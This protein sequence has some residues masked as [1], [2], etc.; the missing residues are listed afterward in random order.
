MSNR[1]GRERKRDCDHRHEVL[2]VGEY[3][4]L[5]DTM[6]GDIR[7]NL[8]PVMI[9]RGARDRLTCAVLVVLAKWGWQPADPLEVRDILFED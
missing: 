9:G 1:R 7:H 4:V 3:V 8:N 2:Y 5:V 6:T